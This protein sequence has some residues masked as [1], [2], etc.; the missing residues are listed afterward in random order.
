M[1]ILQYISGIPVYILYFM[2]MG[3]VSLSLIF[4]FST[5]T[6]F[7]VPIYCMYLYSEYVRCN[8]HLTYM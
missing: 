8:D 7:Y 4:L 5:V 1:C 6:S 2:N 3:K